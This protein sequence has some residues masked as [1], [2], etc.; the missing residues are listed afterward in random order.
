MIGRDNKPVDAQV[1]TQGQLAVAAGYTPGG[2]Q[3]KDSSGFLYVGGN[4]NTLASEMLPVAGPVFPMWSGDTLYV[5]VRSC[6][7]TLLFRR[8]APSRYSRLMEGALAYTVSNTGVVAAASC[9]DVS[10]QSCQLGN[11]L[12]YEIRSPNGHMWLN[13]VGTAVAF[14]QA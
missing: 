1:S 12:T 2:A 5:V 11:P 13:H 9:P 14:S 6:R 10:A 7:H 4:G 8:A 3:C